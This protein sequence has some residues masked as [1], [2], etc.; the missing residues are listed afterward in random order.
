MLFSVIIPAARRNR[1]LSHALSSLLLQSHDEWEAI[2]VGDELFHNTRSLFPHDNRIRF[3]SR[4]ALSTHAA[5]ATGIHAAR[6]SVITF[7]LP[8]DYVSPTHLAKHRDFFHSHPNLDAVFG[9]PTVIGS[10]YRKDPTHPDSH[11][12]VHE[13]PILGASFIREHVFDTLQHLPKHDLRS[14]LTKLGFRTH[15]VTMPSY[16]YDRTVTT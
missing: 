9:K 1:P 6:G 5:C 10:P 11:H 3:I 7:L 16:I 12:H 4:P 2:V 14:H 13:S 8:D 15:T